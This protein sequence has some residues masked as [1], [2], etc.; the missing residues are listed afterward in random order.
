MKTTKRIIIIAV[1]I[2]AMSSCRVTDFTLISTKN[3]ALDSTRTSA[4]RVSACSG[5]IKGAIDKAIE[6]SG[7]KYNAISDGVITTIPFGY[8]IKGTPVKIK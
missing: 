6:K 2:V 8:C 7:S 1:W 3:V 5:S 4:Q